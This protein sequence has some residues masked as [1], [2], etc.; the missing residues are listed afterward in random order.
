MRIF[1]GS[2]SFRQDE[3]HEDLTTINTPPAYRCLNDIYS[4]QIL[5]GQKGW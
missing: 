5:Y 1:R 3:S 2:A 4:I